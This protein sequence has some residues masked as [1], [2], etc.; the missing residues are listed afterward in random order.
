MTSPKTIL[1]SGSFAAQG[2]PYLDP[3]N[4]TVSIFHRA[5]YL[6][7]PLEEPLGVYCSDRTTS[8]PYSF[9][10]ANAIVRRVM[11]QACKLA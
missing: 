3:I 8:T 11:Q 10:I 4:A 1:P 7:V 6:Q 2:H 5:Q 9:N